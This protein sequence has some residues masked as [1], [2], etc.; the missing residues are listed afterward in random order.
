M[1]LRGKI[2]ADMKAAMKAKDALRLSTLRLI[3]SAIKDRD[4]AARTQ[5]DAGDGVSEDEIL[6][7]LQKLVKQREDSAKTYDEAGRPELAQK[8]R[9]EIA[10]LRDYL[11]RPMSEAETGVA[12]AALIDE[13]GAGGMKDMGRVMGAL[14]ERYAG[15]MDFGR[16]NAVVKNQLQAKAG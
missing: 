7:L 12:V 5:A 10:I 6:S 2:T 15:R 1:E 3:Q 4:I 9:A 8:E 11:P 16:A 14:K 13:L